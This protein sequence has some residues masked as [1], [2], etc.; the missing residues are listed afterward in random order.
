MEDLLR[1]LWVL[2]VRGDV[3]LNC[4]HNLRGS[5]FGM[6][7]AEMCLDDKTAALSLAISWVSAWESNAFPI[8]HIDL[9]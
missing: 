3:R 8:L 1:P 2:M 5:I 7:C 9:R 6:E 4:V